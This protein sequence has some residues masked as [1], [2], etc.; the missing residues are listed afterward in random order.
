MNTT[1]RSPRDFTNWL[2]GFLHMKAMLTEDDIEEI[3]GAAE[4]TLMAM[5]SDL[6]D[7]KPATT[8]GTS[9]VGF[10]GIPNC[11]LCF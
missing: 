8:A 2:D 11:S 6:G 10:C 9:R 3:M 1:L 4:D 5:D 7:K